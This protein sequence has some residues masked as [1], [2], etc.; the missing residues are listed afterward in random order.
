MITYQLQKRV[1]RYVRG[2]KKFS[3]PNDLTVNVEYGPPEAFGTSNNP[4][5]LG[6]SGSVIKFIF[7]CNTGRVQ[8]L[9]DPSLSPLSARVEA[10]NALFEL[11]GTTLRL[12]AK[13]E[14]DVVLHNIL[15][16]LLHGLPALLNIEFPDPP[17]MLSLTGK[18]G[19][20]E[21]RWEYSDAA[22]L[23]RRKTEDE[24][25]QHIIDSINNLQ[26][27]QGRLLAA[28]QYFHTASRLIVSGLSSWEFMAESIL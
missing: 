12:Q 16:S 20:V 21:F 14:N 11:K 8:V 27:L 1:L 23:V 24:L 3:F 9:S 19:E 13:C 6:R 18:L 28:T 2:P 10:D 26:F 7:N 4:S 5:R 25:N 15:L 17:I 22:F